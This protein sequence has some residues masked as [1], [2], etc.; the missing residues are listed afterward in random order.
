MEQDFRGCKQ[1][2]PES[3]YAPGLPILRITHGV[4]H[5]KTLTTTTPFWREL[6]GN[7]IFIWDRPIALAVYIPAL[8]D[9]LFT[10]PSPKQGRGKEPP[11]GSILLGSLH[12]NKI[13]AAFPSW[14]NYGR[15]RQS[16]KPNQSPPQYYDK[17]TKINSEIQSQD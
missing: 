5:P 2:S 1:V 13:L 10:S 11:E 14:G 8:Q 3:Q 12:S 17:E 4:T 16:P 9:L 15:K 7:V 6:P